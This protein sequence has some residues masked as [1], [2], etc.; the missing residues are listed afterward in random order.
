MDLTKTH[1]NEIVDG[2]PKDLNITS[3]KKL[4]LPQILACVS[5]GAAASA[6][7]LNYFDN[8]NQGK[9]TDRAKVRR[10]LKIGRAAIDCLLS[11]INQINDTNM[12][13]EDFN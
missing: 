1:E 6:V 13:K 8:K 7:S 12:D 2:C 11:F 3:K 4:S 5:A 10:V 9:Q